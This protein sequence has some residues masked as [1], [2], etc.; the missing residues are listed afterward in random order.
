MMDGSARLGTN[1]MLLSSVLSSPLLSSV[2]WGVR[3]EDRTGTHT[4]S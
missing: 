1:G 2:E 4:H 3:R